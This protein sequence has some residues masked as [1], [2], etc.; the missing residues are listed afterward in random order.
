ML[1]VDTE[2]TGSLLVD[3]SRFIFY[4]ECHGD[5]LIVQNGNCTPRHLSERHENTN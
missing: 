2:K 3:L 4:G 5:Y 1:I